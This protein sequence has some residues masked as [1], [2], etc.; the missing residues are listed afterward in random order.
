M[1][2]NTT[3]VPDEKKVPAE[4]NPVAPTPKEG[5]EGTAA[6]GGSEEQK[7]PLV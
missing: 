4:G 7:N 6:L 3:N 2:E 5:G 1:D